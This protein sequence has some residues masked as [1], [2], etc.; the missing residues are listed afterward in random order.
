[1]S[2]IP[3]L[4]KVTLEGDWDL[5][6]MKQD[7]LSTCEKSSGLRAHEVVVDDYLII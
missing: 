1:M 4:Y 3:D 7:K 5:I 2:G 6:L